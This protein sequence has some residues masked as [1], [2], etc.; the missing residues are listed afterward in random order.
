MAT[1]VKYGYLVDGGLYSTYEAAL[2][3]AT[4]ITDSSDSGH[5]DVSIQLV[6]YT[7]WE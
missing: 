1:V 7:H 3:A 5:K 2:A 4:S 6:T